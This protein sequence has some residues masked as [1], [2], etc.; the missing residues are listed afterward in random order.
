MYN[1]RRTTYKSTL[2][3][4]QRAAKADAAFAKKVAKM[5]ANRT[6]SQFNYSTAGGSYI[7]TKEQYEAA[8]AMLCNGVCEPNSAKAKSAEMVQISFITQTKVHHD[9]I[10]IV[11]EYRRSL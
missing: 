5:E 7:P 11:N 10:H 4:E 3:P 2:T 8:S 1:Y 6:K 9:H